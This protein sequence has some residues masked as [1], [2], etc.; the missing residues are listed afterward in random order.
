MLLK[1][2]LKNI[3]ISNMLQNMCETKEK[4]NEIKNIKQIINSSVS[5]IDSNI[6]HYEWQINNQGRYYDCEKPSIEVAQ[7]NIN[8]LLIKREIEAAVIIEDTKTKIVELSNKFGEGYFVGYSKEEGRYIGVHRENCDYYKT[9]TR[10]NN[11]KFK[12]CKTYNSACKIA[13]SLIGEIQ[14]DIST[15][16]TECQPWWNL[17]AIKKSI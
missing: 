3:N 13:S 12:K 1:K 7:K 9:F 8:E 2:E 16:C 10:G 17:P 15:G 6:R 11:I 5:N 4:P 14:T